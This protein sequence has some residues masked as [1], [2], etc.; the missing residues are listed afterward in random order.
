MGEEVNFDMIR[1]LGLWDW[2]WRGGVG[3]AGCRQGWLWATRWSLRALGTRKLLKR[4]KS[5][6]LNLEHVVHVSSWGKPARYKF[7]DVYKAL[8]TWV[9]MTRRLIRWYFV[10][11]FVSIFVFLNVWSATLT[12]HHHTQYWVLLVL[13]SLWPRSR[14]CVFFLLHWG[15]A[16]WLSLFCSSRCN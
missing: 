7:S 11:L 1:A 4:E 8:V 3:W 5:F 13:G 9:A 14:P 16:A 6:Q 15:G 10:C 2:V 12:E